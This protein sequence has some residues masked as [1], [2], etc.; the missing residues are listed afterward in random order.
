MSLDLLSH[1]PAFDPSEHDSELPTYEQ[2]RLPPRRQSATTGP[3]TH[4]YHLSDKTGNAWLVMKC[5]S[6]SAKP[7]YI[8]RTHA[9]DKIE[10]SVEINLTSWKPIKS[11]QVAVRYRCLLW[12]NHEI[13][14]Y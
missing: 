12:F 11:V 4:S 7:E 5:K 13:D 3:V 10:G 6:R 1:P 9:G 2:I 14:E 8:P